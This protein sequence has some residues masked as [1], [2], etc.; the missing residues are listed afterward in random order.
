MPREKGSHIFEMNSFFFYNFRA[1]TFDLKACLDLLQKS[2]CA[3]VFGNFNFDCL[4][5]CFTDRSNF[6]SNL[7]NSYRLDFSSWQIEIAKYEL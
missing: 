3:F 6:P 2:S 4:V 5:N 7:F 1:E